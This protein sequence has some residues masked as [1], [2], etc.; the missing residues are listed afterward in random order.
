MGT[1]GSGLTHDH[2]HSHPAIVLVEVWERGKPV[3]FEITVTS[4]LCTAFVGEASQVAGAVALA[5]ET[6]Q[7][8]S[9]VKTCQEL[10]WACAPIAVEIYSNWGQRQSRHSHDWHLAWLL[11]HHNQSHC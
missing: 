9:N 10:G 6:S 2:S 1:L 5:A 11:T 3:A 8:I 7:H 4:P